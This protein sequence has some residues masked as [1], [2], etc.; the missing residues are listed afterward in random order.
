MDKLYNKHNMHKDIP[1]ELK[2]VNYYIGIFYDIQIILCGQI[3]S[4]NYIS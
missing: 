4:Y 1:Q 3:S 2:F